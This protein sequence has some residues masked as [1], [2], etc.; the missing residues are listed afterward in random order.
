MKQLQN[1]KDKIEKERDHYLHLTSKLRMA[2]IAQGLGSYHG[3]ICSKTDAIIEKH[4]NDDA[5]FESL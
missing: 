2:V 1:K 3:E 5:D 4:V